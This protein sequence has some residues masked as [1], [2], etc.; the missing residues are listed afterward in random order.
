M[1]TIPQDQP[2]LYGQAFRKRR[3]RRLFQIQLIAR[4]PG[5]QTQT[6]FRLLQTERSFHRQPIRSLASFNQVDRFFNRI[7]RTRLLLFLFP[8]GSITFLQRLLLRCEDLKFGLSATA[9]ESSETQC[10]FFEVIEEH[11]VTEDG[12]PVAPGSLAFDN[13]LI[14]NSSNLFGRIFALNP[15]TIAPAR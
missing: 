2:K 8:H 7:R 10:L 5:R 13:A 3:N 11:W 1:R 6:G 12:H 9:S 4:Q 14:D 15:D